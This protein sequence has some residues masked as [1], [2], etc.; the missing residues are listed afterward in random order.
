MRTIIVIV[1]GLVL[2]CV[3]VFGA[4]F[5]NKGRTS[6]IINGSYWF[7]ALWLVF[8]AIDFYIG[9]FKAGYS[10]KD[11]FLIHLIIFGIPAAAAAWLLPR[12]N[13]N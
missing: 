1:I 12:L 9:V 2:A 8:C 3:F 6:P 11:E 13:S 5:L 4:G 7:I 10:A